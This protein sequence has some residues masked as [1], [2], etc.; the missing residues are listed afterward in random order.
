MLGYCGIDCEKCGAFIA[1]KNNDAALR[2]KT[3]AE[4]TK[5]YNSDIKPEDINC[6]G[7]TAPGVKFRYCADMCEIRKCGIAK[8]VNNCGACGSY[9]CE[10]LEGFFAQVPDAKVNLDKARN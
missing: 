10:K 1:T 8:R 2:V 5:T 9:A 7:C 3:A 4:W 6:A